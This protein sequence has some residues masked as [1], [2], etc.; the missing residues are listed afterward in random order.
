MPVWAESKTKTCARYFA[1]SAATT[2]TF[3]LLRPWSL[4]NP[5]KRKFSCSDKFLF[6]DFNIVRLTNAEKS[7]ISKKIRPSYN[8]A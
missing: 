2:N 3:P 7:A 5:T 8:R 6:I 4:Q 1:D